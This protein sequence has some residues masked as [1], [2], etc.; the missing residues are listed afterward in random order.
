MSPDSSTGADERPILRIANILAVLALV[1]MLLGAVTL[2][3]A[4]DHSSQW[5]GSGDSAQVLDHEAL[6]FDL[7]GA[8][9]QVE[10]RPSWNHS[11]NVTLTVSETTGTGQHQ[12]ETHDVPPGSFL[13]WSIRAEHGEHWT[14]V[15]ENHGNQ[16]VQVVVTVSQMGHYWV[17]G[18]LVAFGVAGFVFHRIGMRTG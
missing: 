2:L 16:S 7:W 18:A 13:H 1:A 5:V 10:V 3:M 11:A 4:R 14:A 6:S 15:L 12:N 8:Q 17:G 9:M